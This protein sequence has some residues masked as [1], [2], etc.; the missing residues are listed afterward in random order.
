MSKQGC[1]DISLLTIAVAAA[2][3]VTFNGESANTCAYPLSLD[4]AG[5]SRHRTTFC[6]CCFAVV[7]VVVASALE[8]DNHIAYE[9]AVSVVRTF[10]R[11]APADAAIV[12]PAST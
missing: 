1:A 10:H 11:F 7:F 2:Q 6:V 8:G 4:Q 3:V 12:M 5:I 9:C